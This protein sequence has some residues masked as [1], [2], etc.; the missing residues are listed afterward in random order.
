MTLVRS[1]TTSSVIRDVWN[2]L[3]KINWREKS[4]TLTL[5]RML[6]LARIPR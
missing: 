2:V 4:G 3:S 1:E 5:E 6:Y